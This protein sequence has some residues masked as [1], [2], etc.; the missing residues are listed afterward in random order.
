MRNNEKYAYYT[1]GIPRNSELHKQL[2]A[3]S[4]EI[5]VSTQTIIKLRLKGQ[6]PTPCKV[7]VEPAQEEEIIDLSNAAEALDSWDD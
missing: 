1:V 2:L 4:Q 5:G 3:E 7:E 6:S